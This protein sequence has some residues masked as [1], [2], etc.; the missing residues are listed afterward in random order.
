MAAYIIVEVEI[1]N[2]VLYEGYKKLTPG[3]LAAFGGKFLARGGEVVTLE[4][5]HEPGRIVILEFP[6][7]ERA[8]EWW[9]SPGYTEARL[10][11]QKAAK[12]RM[13]IVEGISS[14]PG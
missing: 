14:V 9:N 1:N 12:T 10:I 11:R 13:I 2:P 4:G 5:N 6:S 3:T 8:K 7:V